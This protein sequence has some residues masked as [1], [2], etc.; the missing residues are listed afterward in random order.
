MRYFMMGWANQTLT[1]TPFAFIR[2][3]VYNHCAHWKLPNHTFHLS[4]I[5]GRYK[6]TITLASIKQLS[7]CLLKHTLIFLQKSLS[8]LILHQREKLSSVQ[9]GNLCFYESSSSHVL[10]FCGWLITGTGT[11]VFVTQRYARSE[12]WF[13]SIQ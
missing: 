6:H 10:L 7:I 9:R 2:R 5:S 12:K 11:R 4:H 3:F 13:Q 8:L 1:V